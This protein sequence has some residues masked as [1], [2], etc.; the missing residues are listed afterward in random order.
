MPDQ[1]VGDYIA[2][3]MLIKD[4]IEKVIAS[5]IVKMGWTLEQFRENKEKFRS[6]GVYEGMIVGI[7][8][9]LRDHFVSKMVDL[10]KYPYDLFELSLKD[11]ILEVMTNGKKGV[12]RRSLV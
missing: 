2:K 7:E 8:N 9:A 12:Q 4:P 11:T 5:M 10:D 3:L 6:A 1:T